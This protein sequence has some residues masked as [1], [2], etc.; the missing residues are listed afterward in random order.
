[1]G[2]IRNCLITADLIPGT[3]NTIVTNVDN[4]RFIRLARALK[5][6]SAINSLQVRAEDEK[7]FLEDVC[8]KIVEV[9]GYLFSWVGYVVENLKRNIVPVAYAGHEEGYLKYLHINCTEKDPKNELLA[10]AMETD[11]PLICYD[12][13]SAATNIGPWRDE[14][15]KRGYKS[16][17]AIPLYV[18]INGNNAIIVIYSDNSNVFDEEEVKLLKEMA[19]SIVFGIKYIRTL[20]EQR[21]AAEELKISYEKVQRSLLSTIEAFSL[22]MEARDPYTVAHQKKVAFLAGEIAKE[23]GLSDYE[24]ESIKI[25]AT[26]HDVGKTTIPTEILCK[27]GK[28]SE[29]EC[30]FIKTHSQAGYDIVKNIE[31]PWPIAD[32]I[33]QHHER[34]DG[35]GYPRGLKGD[36]I[37]LGARIIAVADVVEAMASPRPYRA[38]LGV[39]KALEEIQS[40]KNITFDGEVVD[41]CLN[42]FNNKGFLFPQE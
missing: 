24:V 9:G 27:P 34:L 25:A 15:L 36:E 4:T 2:K 20:I 28:I 37:S 18:R 26:I 6:T 7:T 40:Q 31:F 29:L 5:A 33:L 42:L 38:A 3:K 22:Q 39:Q 14:A 23:M 41:V 10:R 12:I 19:D 8:Q 21:G 13:A 11:E 32:L 1:M 16:L 35:S 30:M 17:I